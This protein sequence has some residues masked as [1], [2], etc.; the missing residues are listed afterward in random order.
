MS[1]ISLSGR[2]C[3]DVVATALCAL[4]AAC[5]GGG[6]AAAPALAVAGGDGSPPPQEASTAQSDADAAM[7]PAQGKANLEVMAQG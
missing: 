4:L 7:R 5:G 1:C 2:P 3:R 6:D